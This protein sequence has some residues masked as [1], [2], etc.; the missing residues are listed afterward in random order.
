MYKDNK[1]IPTPQKP[2]KNPTE[3]TQP[4]PPTRLLSVAVLLR[5]SQL[6]FQGKLHAVSSTPETN[7]KSNTSQFSPF[8]MIS[9]KV[10]SGNPLGPGFFMWH[11]NRYLPTSLE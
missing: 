1:N 7:G 6:P 9:G 5:R 2:A 10:R 11:E 8:R 3:E 4:E